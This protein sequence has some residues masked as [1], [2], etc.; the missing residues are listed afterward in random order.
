MHCREQETL[1]EQYQQ[2]VQSYWQAVRRMRD[3][4]GPLPLAEL[5]LL[6]ELAVGASKVCQDARGALNRHIQEHGC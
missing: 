3:Y 4:G 1:L 2:A 5:E 6:L